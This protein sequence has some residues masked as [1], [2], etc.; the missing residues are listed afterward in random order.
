MDSKKIIFAPGDLY[1]YTSLSKSPK[2]IENFIRK[3]MGLAKPTPV[4]RKLQS[5]IDSH[6]D[7]K[8]K[9]GLP[10]CGVASAKYGS[11]AEKVIG[12]TFD[13]PL[14]NKLVCADFADFKIR[15]YCD[16][17]TTINGRQYV[18]EIK[19]R[20]AAKPEMTKAEEIQCLAYCNCL[21]I[22]NLEFV[23]QIGDGQIIR[24]TYDNF[25]GDYQVLWSHVLLD[26]AYITSLIKAM[27]A[28][29]AKYII[30]GELDMTKIR[31]F[32]YWL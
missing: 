4:K 27:H 6:A 25:V 17:I 24:Q 12:A 23:Q 32:I 7:F 30:D 26:L 1:S 9:Q 14:A 10:D 20:L 5:T 16:G 21:G 31:R 13:P 22:P 3:H 2:T 19:T 28:D 18:V 8:K 15:G 29:P 11:R